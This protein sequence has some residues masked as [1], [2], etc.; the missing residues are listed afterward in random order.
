M[1]DVR[2]ISQQYAPQ[3]RAINVDVDRPAVGRDLSLRAPVLVACDTA[4][5]VQTRV[6][7]RGGIDR[8]HRRR[9]EERVVRRRERLAQRI[10]AFGVEVQAIALRPFPW[11]RIAFK[12]LDLD[13]RTTQSVREA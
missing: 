2:Q 7:D 3:D 1:A 10:D 5:L 4:Q 6:E 8:P 13:V 11:T 9:F 12:Y